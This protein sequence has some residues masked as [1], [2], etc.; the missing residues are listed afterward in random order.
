MTRIHTQGCY[1]IKSA[2]SRPI[3]E[4]DLR[5]LIDRSK[6]RPPSVPSEADRALARAVRDAKT[7]GR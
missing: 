4:A 5:R 1:V 2:E 7:K 6:P 3:R